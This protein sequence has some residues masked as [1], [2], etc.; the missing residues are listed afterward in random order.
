M[1]PLE[2]SLTCFL[3][4]LATTTLVF[5]SSLSV[6]VRF[7]NKKSSCMFLKDIFCNIVISLWEIGSGLD[8]MDF[9][10]L[11]KNIESH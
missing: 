4:L 8:L 10:T 9:R 7:P 3:C 5:E 11:W 2:A 1:W 6:T